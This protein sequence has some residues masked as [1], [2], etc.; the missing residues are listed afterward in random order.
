LERLNETYRHRIER[1]VEHI[2][3][4]LNESLSLHQLAEI[5]CF[6]PYHFHRIFVAVTGETVHS[7]TQ[8]QRV[9]KAARL[10]KFS[11]Q[12]VLHISLDVGFSSSATFSRSFKQY[13]GLSPSE[14]RKKGNL[15]NSKIGKQL[16]PISQYLVPM[17][18][19]ENKNDFHVE[20][21]EFPERR[22][23][24]IRV[25]DSFREGV[26]LKAYEQLI[27]W[28]KEQGI[29]ESESIFGMSLDDITITP[30]NKYRY[31]VCL[32]IPETL[33]VN[34]QHISTMTLPKCQY[35]TTVV[36][37]NIN[38]VTT[39]FNYLYNQWLIS[40]SY[41]PE[42]QHALELFLDKANVCNWEH[43]DLKLCVPVKSL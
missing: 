13:F 33:Q 24:Y 17:A 5:A 8:R 12:S 41:E 1:V 6:S 36:S 35:A 23:A 27:G 30:K 26:V 22:I 19:G 18:L 2:N 25:T 43:F 14:F 9:E 39:A 7:F 3:N 37:G 29:Y 31:E 11:E 40:S 38:Q 42:H 34:Q 10:L 21:L 32:T 4:N 15:E 28:A 20:L 16:F